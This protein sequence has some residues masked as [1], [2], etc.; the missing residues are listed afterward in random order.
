MIN[1]DCGSGIAL[2]VP[3]RDDGAPQ[4]SVNWEWLK[5]FWT[6]HL[7]AAQ[8]V[9]GVDEGTP[10]SKTCAVNNAFQNAFQGNDII[11]ILDADCYIAP[12]VI[13]ECAEA[14][15]EA[16]RWGENLWFVPYR[17]LYRLTDEATKRLIASPVENP[18]QFNVPHVLEDVVSLRQATFGHRFGAL[19]QIMPRDG[20]IEVG[21]MDPRFRGWG[22]EDSSMLRAMD[23]LYGIHRQ[24]PN[25][26]M[27]LWHMSLGNVFLRMW[28]GEKR[29][30]TNSRYSIPYKN[31]ER[32]PARTRN[33]IAE[34]L[35]LPVYK[36]NRIL[37]APPWFNGGNYPPEV[38]I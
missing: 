32:D 29:T 28:E 35:G 30:G 16:R 8:L 6:H 11:V 18:V 23:T 33:L 9:M 15:R 20:F 13:V 7:P 14:I 36:E 12:I 3:Y 38:S 2:L 25:E 21:G 10:F 19:I 24:S 1:H 34:W 22:G 17:F 37:P 5:R 4:R 27:T 31:A 26:V